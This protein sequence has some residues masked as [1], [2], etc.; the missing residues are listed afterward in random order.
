MKRFYTNTGAKLLAF[1]LAAVLA[2][3]AVL[4][5]CTACRLSTILRPDLEK[6]NAQSTV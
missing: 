6:K 4:F 2:I 5:S 1:L 3:S